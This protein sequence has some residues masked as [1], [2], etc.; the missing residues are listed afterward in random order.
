M[1]LEK[2]GLGRKKAFWTIIILS[3]VLSFIFILKTESESAFQA[4]LFYCVSVLGFIF[5]TKVNDTNKK[6]KRDGEKKND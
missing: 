2:T 3:S 1:I 6:F 5:G 4:Y